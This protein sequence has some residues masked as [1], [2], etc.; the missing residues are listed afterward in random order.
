M[1]KTILKNIFV[2]LGMIIFSVGITILLLE[3][4]FLKSVL[5]ILP[6]KT[7]SYL[8]RSIQVFAQSSKTSTIPDDYILVVGDSYAEGKGDWYKEIKE[9]VSRPDFH[10][11]HLIH[12]STGIDVITLGDSGKGSLRGF[13]NKSISGYEFANATQFEIEQP[14]LI[15]A[16]FYEGNDLHNN[17]YAIKEHYKNA[18]DGDDVFDEEEFSE[19]ISSHVVERSR[20]YKNSKSPEL[21]DLKNK[22]YLSRFFYDLAE[23]NI[24]YWIKGP[25][26]KKDRKQYKTDETNTVL[27]SGEEFVIP[28][29]LEGPALDLSDKEIELGIYVFE[30]SLRYL[31]EYFYNSKL[32]VVYIPSPMASYNL[33]SNQVSITQMRGM[34]AGGKRVFEMAKVAENSNNIAAKISEIALSADVHFID[35][36]GK[37]REESEFK[38]IHGPVDW[39]HLNKAGYTALADVIVEHIENMSL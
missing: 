19:F 37:L 8:D 36:R 21:F 16:Y 15:L 3:F 23:D 13:L 39:L 14:D 25:K 2:P 9:K 12:N 11:T 34:P 28:Q 24:D 4:V 38:P 18:I 7:H 1:I 33:T 22:F 32:A 5:N 17:V 27:I 26:I 31:K 29:Y 30:Q 35:S 6:L 10:S 20:I